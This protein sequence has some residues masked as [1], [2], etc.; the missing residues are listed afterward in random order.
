MIEGIVGS[1][2]NV[3]DKVDVRLMVNTKW[4]KWLAGER[5]TNFFRFSFLIVLSYIKRWKR[6]KIDME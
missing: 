6:S 4:G 2:E 3:R 5:E 1:G